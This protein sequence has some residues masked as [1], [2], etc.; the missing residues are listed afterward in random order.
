MIVI[1]RQYGDYLYKVRQNY[2]GAVQQYIKTIGQLEPSYVI[3]QFLDAHRIQNLTAYLQ[4]LHK[5]KKAKSE[6]TTLLLNCYTKLKD[7]QKLDEFIN[8][9]GEKSFDVHT[10]IKV[11]RE[12]KYF[13]HALQLAKKM[14]EHQWYVRIMLEDKKQYLDA[15]NYISMQSFEV[16]RK[17]MIEYGK[18]LVDKIPKQTTELLKKLC[19]NFGMDLSTNEILRAD[20][21][22]YIKLYVIQL[23]Y[24]V[25]FL[26]YM[27]HNVANLKP[28]IYNTLFELY[29][30]QY[31][32]SKM[33][34][35]SSEAAEPRNTTGSFTS[36]ESSH[37]KS[38]VVEGKAMS[39]LRDSKAPYD[40]DHALILCQMHEFRE[41]ILYLYEKTHLYKHIVKYHMDHE[42][43]DKVIEMCKAHGDKEPSL[44]RDALIFFGKHEGQS[45]NLSYILRVI[46]QRELLSPLLVVQSLA[47]NTDV[48]V[49][50]LKEYLIRKFRQESNLI[51]EE[52]TKIS[53]LKVE[54]DNSKR[55]IDD[56]KKEPQHFPE[57]SK[58]STCGQELYNPS[59]HFYCKHSYHQHC[60]ESFSENDQCPLCVLNNQRFNDQ[61]ASINNRSQLQEEFHAKLSNT[62]SDGFS[63]VSQYFGFGVF[64]DQK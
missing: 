27:T 43:F 15:L 38:S 25:D 7:T 4:E 45:E 34:E 47:Q 17:N 64:S 41:G 29:L 35:H 40:M 18:Q 48:K 61:W 54:I 19:T 12:A 46:E 50:V 60:F 30:K 51:D 44:W 9:E 52:E 23:D 22:D 8:S 39:L 5:A 6:H 59:V 32:D 49:G 37:H 33:E 20:P 3:R 56:L 58:C 31:T 11:C 28:I 10:A 13:D 14:N 21:E 36:V 24:L 62:T 57:K 42:E 55:R 16:V 26:E 63:V 53:K 2:D 1:F